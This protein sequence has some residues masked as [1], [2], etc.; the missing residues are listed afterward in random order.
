[1]TTHP[2]RIG[3]Q[4]E[5]QHARAVGTPSGEPDH[6]LSALRRWLSWRETL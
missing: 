6:D 3:V 2:I 1:V 5:Q 4:L